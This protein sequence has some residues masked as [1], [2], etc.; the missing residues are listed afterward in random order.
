V[1][2]RG[3]KDKNRI[4]GRF[5][6]SLE[7]GIESLLREHVHLVYDINAVFTYLG[8]YA[9]LVCEITDVIDGV[10]GSGIQFVYAV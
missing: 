5:L 7:E 6:Q 10:V 8:R 9:N 4:R 1:L 3:S 2:F